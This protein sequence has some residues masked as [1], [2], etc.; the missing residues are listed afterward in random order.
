MTGPSWPIQ[1]RTATHWGS[2]FL[3]RRKITT[4]L[5]YAYYVAFGPVDTSL[6]ELVSVAGQRWTIEDG[7]E[8]AKGEIGLDHYEFC[9]GPDGTD[10]SPCPSWH[11]PCSPSPDLGVR[12]RSR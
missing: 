3:V 4:S 2:W 11:T 6:G 8:R 5:K 10:T 1:P 7:F 12:S 9:L